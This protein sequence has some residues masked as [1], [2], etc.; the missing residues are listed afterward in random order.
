M[1]RH[2]GKHSRIGLVHEKRND[3]GYLDAGGAAESSRHRVCRA[4]KI[5]C[6]ES[7]RDAR[8]E[9]RESFVRWARSPCRLLQRSG[10]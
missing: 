6:A 4:Q 10:L 3:P 7:K 9:I 1:K 2:F 8:N 5:V